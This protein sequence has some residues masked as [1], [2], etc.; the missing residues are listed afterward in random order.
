MRSFSR[1]LEA[2]SR[3]FPDTLYIENKENKKSKTRDLFECSCL[4]NEVTISYAG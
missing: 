3:G 2:E 1:I 4:E